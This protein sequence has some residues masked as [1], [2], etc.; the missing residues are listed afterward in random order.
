MEYENQDQ[1]SVNFTIKYLGSTLVEAASSEGATAEAIKTIL[2]VAKVSGKK[3]QR[4]LVNVSLRGI[5]ITDLSTDEELLDISIYRISY[6][7]ADASHDHVFAF[8]AANANETM[9]C[10]AFLCPK[11]KV[12]QAVTL[13]VAKAFNA[14]YEAWRKNEEKRN[15]IIG[16]CSKSIEASANQSSQQATIVRSEKGHDDDITD[17]N[18]SV[19]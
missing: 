18:S 17:K 19:F 14:A 16:E 4:V 12:T 9:E 13:T 1:D 5:R 6:C 2:R 8:I 15:L 11:R 3:L 10:H 7:S